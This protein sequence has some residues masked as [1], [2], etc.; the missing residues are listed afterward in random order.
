MKREL[1]TREVWFYIR[2]LI[3][4][5][6]LS[7]EELLKKMLTKKPLRIR[8]RRLEF[9][10]RKMRKECLENMT[11]TEHIEGRRDRGKQWAT[12]LTSLRKW[13]AKR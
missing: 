11:L 2:M 12:Y 7:K 3:I 6:R 5:R 1:E 8:K 9:L 4:P 10:G 13:M